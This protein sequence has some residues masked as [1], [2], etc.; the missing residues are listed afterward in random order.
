M[1]GIF[2]LLRLILFAAIA[3]V[4]A[5]WITERAGASAPIDNVSAAPGAVFLQRSFPR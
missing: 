3:L 1:F 4:V 2:R 5:W